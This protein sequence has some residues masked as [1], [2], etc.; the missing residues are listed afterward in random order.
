MKNNSAMTDETL[1]ELTLIGNDSAYEELVKRHEKAVKGAAYKVTGSEYFAEDASQDAF[2]SAWMNLSALR[3]PSRFRPWVCSIAKNCA[4]R[5]VERYRAAI[6]DISLSLFESADTENAGG[7]AFDDEQNAYS[8]LHEAVEALDGKIREAVKLHY[9]EGLSVARI[10]AKLSLPEGT[11]K[12]RL[13]EGRK[14][15]RK[16]YGIMENEYDENE[17]MVRKVMRQIERLKLWRLKNDRSGFEAEFKEVLAGAEALEDSKEKSRALSDVLMM[18]Y[19]W[20]PGSRNAETLERIK[21]HAEESRNDEVMMPLLSGETQDKTE[22]EIIELIKEKQIPYAQGLGMKKTLGY[23]YFWLGVRLCDAGRHEE[24]MENFKT[25][26]SVLRPVD[27]YYANAV[28]AIRIEEKVAEKGL[29]RESNELAFS[30]CGDEYR[31]IDGKLWFWQEPGYS[32]GNL[33]SVSE[34]GIYWVSLCDGLIIDPDMKAGDVKTASDGITKLTCKSTGATFKTPAGVFENCSVFEVAGASDLVH[35]TAFCPGVGMVYQ[36]AADAGVHEHFLNKYQIKGGSGLLPL[37]AG[38]RWEYV[39]KNAFM[40][41]EFENVLEITGAKGGKA[42][43]AA[44]GFS[45][46]AGYDET[47]WAGNMLNACHNYA[48]CENGKER[49]VDMTECFAKALQLAKTKR[50]KTHTRIAAGIMERIL[51]TDPEFNPEY[52]E[53][54]R[55]N[56][57]QRCFARCENGRALICEDDRTFS[58]EY[59]N[60]VGNMGENGVGKRLLYNMLY[61]IVRDAAG[62]MWSDKWVPGYTETR[63]CFVRGYSCRLDLS[64]FGEERAATPAGTFENC[65]RVVMEL[66]GLPGGLSYRAGKMEC[67]YAPGVGIVTF[68]RPLNNGGTDNVSNVW[69]LTAYEGTGDGYFPIKDGLFRRYEPE[70]TEGWHGSVEYTYDEDENGVV[71]FFDQLGTQDRASYEAGTK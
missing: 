52:A 2:V 16:G 4:I 70:Y 69:Y 13:S 6:P 1:V 3:D 20:L 47:S 44:Y 60:M 67:V 24:G 45:H 64:V 27:V 10:A 18:G 7:V 11:V 12:W 34:P 48:V 55:W 8:D 32:R 50:E 61:A 66:S 15:L 41:G 19:S 43:A 38:N 36:K 51:K 65:R 9:F 62:C 54:G 23:L 37:A 59:K 28:A 42:V 30:A 33:W 5:A 29:G 68:S 71:I 53:C 63:E 46:Y 31:S 22:Q 39:T 49:L 58:F 21:K 35:E 56:F 14:R 17:T 40:T 57:F 25:V 26:L